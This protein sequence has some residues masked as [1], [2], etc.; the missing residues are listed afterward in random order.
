MESRGNRAAV[1]NGERP[2]S[3]RPAALDCYR[4]SWAAGSVA[5][6]KQKSLNLNCDAAFFLAFFSPR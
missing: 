4:H 2:G 5:F 3:L 6:S 1:D